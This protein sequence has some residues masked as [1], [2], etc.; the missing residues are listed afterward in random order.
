MSLIF[1]TSNC[2]TAASQRSLWGQCATNALKQEGDCVTEFSRIFTLSWPIKRSNFMSIRIVYANRAFRRR[3][4]V[5]PKRGAD[6]S[7]MYCVCTTINWNLIV[8]HCALDWI[9]RHTFSPTA[10]KPFLFIRKMAFGENENH[11]SARH[12]R[13]RTW[14]MI[15]SSHLSPSFLSLLLCA[16]STP[17]SSPRRSCPACHSVLWVISRGPIKRWV[18]TK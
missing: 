8:S 14:E 3:R 16:P 15:V 5:P 6:E 11:Q 9:H 1:Q 18:D 4:N 10:N 2:P 12:Q 13:V 17:F 7:L